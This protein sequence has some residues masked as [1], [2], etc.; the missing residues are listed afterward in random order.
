M[1]I[2]TKDL[3]YLKKKRTVAVA[4]RVFPSVPKKQFRCKRTQR[5]LI[6]L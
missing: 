3:F 6:T 5:D 4:V 1:K 2:W